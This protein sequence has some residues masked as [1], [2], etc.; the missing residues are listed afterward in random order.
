MLCAA[1]DS[2]EEKEDMFR[3]IKAHKGRV[4]F[5]A[6]DPLQTAKDKRFFDV[7]LILCTAVLPTMLRVPSLQRCDHQVSP[8]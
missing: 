2:E 4:C 8:G 3:R 1:V 6:L 7:R 5:S